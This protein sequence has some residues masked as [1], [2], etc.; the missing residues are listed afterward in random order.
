MPRAIDFVSIEKRIILCGQNIVMVME[1]LWKR[2]GSPKR[3]W[4][5]NTRNDSPEREMSGDETQLF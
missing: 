4:L 3:K 1:V 2:R 5:D